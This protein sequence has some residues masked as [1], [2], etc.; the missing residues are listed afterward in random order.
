MVRGF[1]RLTTDMKLK[2]FYVLCSVVAVLS[3]HLTS[4]IMFKFNFEDAEDIENLVSGSGLDKPERFQDA[5]ESE[6]EPFTEHTLN[7]LV[8]P[9]SVIP[10]TPPEKD[11]PS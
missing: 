3:T 6:L 1:A 5:T 9:Q 10:T 2:F 4:T 7:Q 11:H 8:C